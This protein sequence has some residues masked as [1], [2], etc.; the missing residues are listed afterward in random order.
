MNEIY[1]QI[2]NYF[3]TEKYQVIPTDSE[4]V[5]MFAS[6]VGNNLYLINVIQLTD[7]YQFDPHRFEDY[8]KITENQFRDVNASK[9]ILLNLMVTDQMDEVYDKINYVPDLEQFLIDINWLVD[10]KHKALIIPN[11]QIN[12]MIGLE[13]KLTEVLEGRWSP[14]QHSIVEKK[15]PSFITFFLIAV[16]I[17]IWIYMEYKG[18]STRNDLLIQFGA[19]DS[20]RTFVQGQYWRLFTSMF[21][22][23][24]AAHLFYNCFGLYIF[25]TRIEKVTKWY[26]FV[27]IYLLSGLMGGLFS[28]TSA[29][30]THTLK[31]AA[32]ASG[33]IYGLMGGLLAFNIKTRRNIGGLTS[34]TLV[35]MLISGIVY[36]VVNQ[37]IDNLAHLGGFIG[38]FVVTS[39]L[40]KD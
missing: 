38:G 25:G 5:H 8:K 28:L 13:N 22:H 12:Q 19:M 2:C 20:Y 10:I 26:Q 40:V 11:K 15:K 14:R 33:G 27:L 31:I 24:G 30:L 32:G 18:G 35:I 3:I 1:E 29:V 6:F 34:A 23:I 4:R 7:V 37:G 16:N 21:L 36:G 9:L 17:L 39:L